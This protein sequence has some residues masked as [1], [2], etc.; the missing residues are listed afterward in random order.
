MSEL[1]L[2]PLNDGVWRVKHSQHGHV[3]NL[4]LI[5]GVWKFKAVGYG[6]GGEVIPGGGPLTDRHNTVIAAPDE[7]LLHAAL[8]SP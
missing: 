4:K 7:A 5:G 1:R 3:G 8:V 6:T 2:E